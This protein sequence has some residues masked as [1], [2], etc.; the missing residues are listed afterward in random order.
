[1]SYADLEI[2]L[3]RW[4]ELRYTI[5]LRYIDSR[6]D[7]DKR[8]SRNDVLPAD[9]DPELLLQRFKDDMVEYGAHLTQ[10]LFGNG[11]LLG[12]FEMARE[13]REETR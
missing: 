1:M 3:H 10:V 5:E 12:L 4:N 6:L 7:S 9:L 13:R 8:V 2:G 11:E